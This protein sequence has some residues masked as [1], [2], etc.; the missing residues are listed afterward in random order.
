M[1]LERLVGHLQYAVPA[2]LDSSVALDLGDMLAALALLRSEETW[3]SRRLAAWLCVAVGFACRGEDLE[4]GRV[5][6][7]TITD[8]GAGYQPALPKTAAGVYGRGERR[9]APHLPVALSCFCVTAALSAL[10]GAVVLTSAAASGSALP[11]VPAAESGP[12]A[13]KP[14]PTA[15]GLAALRLA[16]VRAGRPVP[17]FDAHVG[18]ASTAGLYF[19]ALRLDAGLR[20][21]ISGWANGRGTTVERHYMSMTMAGLIATAHSATLA[22]GGPQCCAAAPAGVVHSSP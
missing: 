15:A 2:T 8:R 4:R 14:W 7:L 10:H 9:V 22:D 6:E 16:L 18:R 17:A 5:S 21:A 1:R 13:G 19:Q 20:N 12:D 11:L 3:E